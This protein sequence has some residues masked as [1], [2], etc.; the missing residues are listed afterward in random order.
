MNIIY[1]V[2]SDKN[3]LDSTKDTIELYIQNDNDGIYFIED[4]TESDKGFTNGLLYS[5]QEISCEFPSEE[6]Q[7]TPMTVQ[8]WLLNGSDFTNMKFEIEYN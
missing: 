4:N 1:L 3:P 5:N 6:N 2:D 8:G 7:C